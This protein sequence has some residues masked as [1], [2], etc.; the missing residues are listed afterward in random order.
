[1]DYTYLL[2]IAIILIFT[3]AF[4]LLSKVIK[5]PQVV[6][7]LVA[8]IILGPVCLNLVSLDNA[9]ILSNLSEIGVIVLMFV[10]GLETDIREMKKCGLASSI[11]ALIGVTAFLF[12]TADPTLSTSTF[13]QDVFVGVILTATSVSIT[14]ETLKELG[15]LN[16]RAGNA[17]LGAAL[18]DDVLG[19]IA[20]TVITSL[21]DP[22]S[23][24]IGIVI[25]KILGF[26]AFA[27]LFGVFFHFVFNKWTQRTEENQRR[28]V[29]VSFA[30]CLLFAY[31]AEEFFGVA[32][33][34]GS[35]VA[36][37]VISST[38]KTKYIAHRFDTM[39]Y[40][41][42]S[43]IFFA[44][45]GLKVTL[46]NMTPTII[47]FAVVL[48]VVAILSKVVGCGLGAKICRYTNKE[49]LQIG[50]GMISRGEV[51]LIVADKGLNMGLMSSGLFGPIVIMVVIT[52]VVTPILLKFVFKDK[53]DTSGEIKSKEVAEVTTSDDSLEYVPG[54][55]N[56]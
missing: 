9:P 13:L 20:L 24:N 41:L 12:G 50:V 42:L 10:A 51:A 5:L 22:E 56:V 34:T 29:I 48:L 49:A 54:Q 27:L 21:A 16:T 4:G 44:S 2:Y 40:L 11:I 37:L 23:G 7:A 26:F 39:S 46:T 3:K 6:G 43:P 32:D 19:I 35:F 14:V 31:V 8:G 15:K 52:T 30:L 18:I 55:D 53:N 38:S 47:I 25:L 1:M 17:I 28:Y 45:I 36:G 33:I